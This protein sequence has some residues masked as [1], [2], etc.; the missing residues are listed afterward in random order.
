MKT[1]VLVS[2]PQLEESRTQRFLW[3]SL[4]A[5]GVEWRHLEKH[6]PDGKIDVEQEQ[7]LLKEQERIIFQFP[8]Y[9]YSSPPLLKA[10]QDEVLTD[11]F[12]FGAKGSQLEGKEFGLVV[13]TAIPER[14]YQAGG[15]ESF[16]TSE[17]LRPFQAMAQKVGMVYLPSFLISQF[18]YQTE[19]EQKAL[20]IR[21]QQ[22]L[23]KAYDP[24]LVSAEAW[25]REQLE[26]WGK[27]GLTDQE[28]QLVDILIQ[29]M[30]ENR[31]RLDDLNWTLREMKGY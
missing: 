2:H 17:L 19:N 24:S 14:E 9:W 5:Q 16:T 11:E 1:I 7:Q 6:Y 13:S 21:Y 4:P 22:Y 15:R 26:S 31:E 28:G 3:E 29:Q 18:D 20:L 23:T 12:I 8:L 25:F 10:W 27:Q 30:E